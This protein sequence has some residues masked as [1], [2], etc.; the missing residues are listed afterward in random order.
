MREVLLE[1]VKEWDHHR[2]VEER[3]AKVE[4]VQ[5]QDHSKGVQEEIKVV[6]EGIREKA[7]EKEEVTMDKVG[8]RVEE[9]ENVA[10]MAVNSTCALTM[11]TTACGLNM[12]TMGR[13]WL[14]F[15]SLSQ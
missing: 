13:L 1:K 10:N 3:E 7:G 8:R 6:P 14:P 9:A 11:T 15:S 2:A 12:R 4:V 5:D